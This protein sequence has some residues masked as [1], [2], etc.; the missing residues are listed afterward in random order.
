M[1]GTF[2]EEDRKKLG[3]FSNALL[4][5]VKW[6]SIDT[7]E[8]MKVYGLLMWYNSLDKKIADNLLEIKGEGSLDEN[9][10][11]NIDDNNT[12]PGDDE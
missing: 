1:K 10:D 9:L 6:D 12:A 5:H 8:L 11:N 2:S 4:K 7:K 3:E